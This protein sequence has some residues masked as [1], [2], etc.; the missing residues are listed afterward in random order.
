MHHLSMAQF[1]NAAAGKR[2][3]GKQ[4]GLPFLNKAVRQAAYNSEL[5]SCFRIQGSP[6]NPSS[7]V[8]IW[9]SNLRWQ[10]LFLSFS[11]V[12]CRV[13]SLKALGMQNEIHVSCLFFLL[14]S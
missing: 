3:T 10:H 9:M 2:K 13:H 6:G 14:H 12:K 11:S 5:F 7:S 4:V 8:D 1:F